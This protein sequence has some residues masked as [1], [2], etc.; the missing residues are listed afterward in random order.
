MSYHIQMP[1]SVRLEE[2]SPTFGRFI[3]QP[4][5]RGYGVTIGNA[6]RRVLLS[7]LPGVAFIGVRIAGVLHEFATVPGVIEDVADIVLNLKAVRLR[8]LVDQPSGRIQLKVKGPK[9]F[10][11]GDIAFATREYEILNPEQPIATL[12]RDGELELELL[13][14]EGKGYVPAED[15]KLPDHPIGLIAMDAIFTPI[16]NVRY[17]V[18]NTRVGQRTDYEKLILEVTTDGSIRPDMALSY[19]A[20]ILREHLEMFIHFD[21]APVLN[22]AAE[23]PGSSSA[24]ASASGGQEDEA[25][26]QRIRNL[27]RMSVDE[28]ELSVRAQNCLKAANIRTIADLVQYDEKRM[29]SFRNFGKKSLAEIVEALRERGLSFGMDVR[30]YLEPESK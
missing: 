18:E 1:N 11:A 13:V 25:E 30:R 27:L 15:N 7:S 14:G 23:G 16:K 22:K 6:L 28:L 21:K 19:A 3:M 8:K 12:D 29:L 26:V 10:R 24:A 4:L 5:E 20:Q 17:V 9:H 2:S